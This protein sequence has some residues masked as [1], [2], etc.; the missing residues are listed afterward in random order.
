M[1]E[2]LFKN[3]TF[4]LIFTAIILNLMIEAF[5]RHSIVDSFKFLLSNPIGFFCNVLIILLTLSLVLLVRRRR[6]FYA[7]LCTIWIG[8][9]IAN[10]IVLS[11]RVTPLTAIDVALIGSTISVVKSYMSYFQMGLIV[12]ALVLVVIGITFI[13]FKAPKFKGKINYLKSVA[14]IAFIGIAVTL[15]LKIGLYTGSLASYFGNIAFAYLDYGFPYCFS[16]TLL[17]TGIDKPKNYSED[18]ILSLFNNIEYAEGSNDNYVSLASNSDSI[19]TKDNPNII[20]IQLESFFDPNLVKYLGF[21][22]NPI[23]NFTALKEKYSTGYLTVPSIGAGTANTEFEIL[24][25]M[26]LDFFGP[27]EYPYKTILKETTCESVNYDLKNLG[28]STHAIHNNKGTFYGRN[29][30]FSQL[31]FDTFTSLEY[32]KNIEETPTNWTKDAVLLDEIM[33]S[34]NST[35]NEDFIY[36]I[37]VQSHGR[38]PSEPILKNPKI[39]L[40]GMDG[41]SDYYSF[42]YFINQ[43]N[44]V[45][46]FIGNLVDTL[47][48]YDEDTVLVLFGDHLP[49]LG[50]ENEDLVNGDI[51]QTEYVMWSNFDLPKE[52]KDLNAYQLTSYI[53]D[54]LG[55]NEGILTKYHQKF[56]NT[57]E[58]QDNLELLQ[59]DMLY[60]ERYI[61]GGENPFIA[62]DLQMGIDKIEITDLITEDNSLIIKGNNFTE[63]SIVTINNEKFDTV[64]IDENTLKVEDATLNVND[65]IAVRQCTSGGGNLSN[66]EPIIYQ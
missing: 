51:F 37:T 25:G 27:G 53:M 32:M 66:T 11:C 35:E 34:L 58:Y 59:Y 57:E 6:F 14:T 13:W 2:K 10:G 1:K 49:T 43:L 61:Y 4:I 28:Y 38:Y 65:A 17:N 63:F 18:T 54:R 31:G 55:M 29:F 64:F 50:F 45:D 42:E 56:A 19:T 22:E 23:P 20:M 21:S 15:S 26:S 24:S 44:E 3:L 5:S 39:T 16:N 12:A 52:D 33:K 36:T 8:F 47:S 46:T 48:Q 40:D 7:L 30:V 62:T 60:G 41:R 9:G